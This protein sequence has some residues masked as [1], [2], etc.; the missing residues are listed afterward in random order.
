MTSLEWFAVGCLTTGALVAIAWFVIFH[1]RISS[2]VDRSILANSERTRLREEAEAER[3]AH[4]RTKVEKERLESGLREISERRR[5]ALEELDG[6]TGNKIRTYVVDPDLLLNRI[7]E[8]LG[9]PSSLGGFA[10]DPVGERG[11]NSVLGDSPDSRGD[12]HDPGEFGGTS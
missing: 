3:T 10:P 8:L 7:D 6:K 11:E 2:E 9:G 1:R 4:E 5:K 12:G